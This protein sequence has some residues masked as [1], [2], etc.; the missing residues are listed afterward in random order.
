MKLESTIEAHPVN[1]F[2]LV[3]NEK[4]VYTCSNDGTVKA[5]NISSGEFGRLIYENS[6]HDVMKLYL[7]GDHDLYAGD[8]EGNV[9]YTVNNKL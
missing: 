2:D 6:K 4:F 1:V 9:K 8:V 5:W 3:A 7:C